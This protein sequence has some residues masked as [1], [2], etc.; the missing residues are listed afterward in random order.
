[1]FLY[2]F[3]VVEQILLLIIIFYIHLGYS[4]NDIVMILLSPFLG[5]NT[6]PCRGIVGNN[7]STQS[8]GHQPSCILFGH[9]PHILILGIACSHLAIAC[10]HI[11][12]W[13]LPLQYIVWAL[14]LGM[15]CSYLSIA[16]LSQQCVA[17]LEY[18]ELYFRSLPNHP[19]CQ[20]NWKFQQR[21]TLELLRSPLRVV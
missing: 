15:D 17:V 10:T 5:G 7:Q 21:N 9:C 13:V 20:A 12:C 1:M 11:G 8:A 6:S 2:K 14:Q 19:G 18:I 4:F 3:Y 16:V